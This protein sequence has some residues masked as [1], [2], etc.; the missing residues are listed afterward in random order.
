MG[1]TTQFSGKFNFNGPLSAPLYSFLKK[2]NATRRMQRDVEG[3]GIQGEFYVDGGGSYGQGNEKNIL[4]Y[5]QPPSTQPGL[6]MKW[7]PTSDFM[8]LQWD[9]VE[10]FYDYTEWLVYLIEKIFK[11]NKYVLNGKMLYQGEEVGDSGIIGII[12]NVVLV[13]QLGG[14]PV[15]QQPTDSMRTDIVLY[16]EPNL[17][18]D[19]VH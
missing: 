3:Y 16:L 2:L 7:E 6:W 11:P 18:P 5:N 14:K 12:D 10:K 4:N 19:A 13:Q 9:G 17:L 1:Y 8:G 15:I